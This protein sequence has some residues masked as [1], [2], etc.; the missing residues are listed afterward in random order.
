MTLGGKRLRRG[1]KLWSVAG[2]IAK[3]ELYNNFRKTV[4]VTEDGEINYPDG[5]AHLLKVDAEYLQQLCAEQLGTKRDRNG[6]P[7]REWQKIRERN[8]ALDTYLYARAAASVAGLD[9]F[10]ERHWAEMERQLNVLAPP[11]TVRIPQGSR[12]ATQR[13]GLAASGTSRRGRQVIRSRW[14]R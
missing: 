4:E 6:Y 3:L 2:H 7:I 9:R 13:G 11:D 14:L 5:Y 10:E 1:I 8:E 12:E